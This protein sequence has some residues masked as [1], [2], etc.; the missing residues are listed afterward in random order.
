M[1]CPWPLFVFFHL[2]KLTFQFLQKIYVK[3]CPSYIWCWDSNPRPS[4]HESPPIT[5]RPGFPPIRVF[6][7]IDPWPGWKVKLDIL[8]SQLASVHQSVSPLRRSTPLRSILMRAKAKET[9]SEWPKNRFGGNQCDQIG[10]FWRVLFNK[11]A[12]KNSPNNW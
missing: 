10:L 1:D 12:L 5:T 2:F 6:Y 8:S 3:K 4:E 11:I 7:N 9:I